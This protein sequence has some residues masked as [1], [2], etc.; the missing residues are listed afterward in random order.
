MHISGCPCNGFGG[1]YA[2]CE[3]DQINLRANTEALDRHTDALRQADND[4]DQRI[5]DLEQEVAELR[6]QTQ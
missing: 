3:C 1:C 2:R 5:A 6:K 4:K